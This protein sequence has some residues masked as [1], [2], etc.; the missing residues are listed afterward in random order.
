VINGPLRRNEECDEEDRGD[1]WAERENFGF[2][3]L[4]ESWVLAAKRVGR[5]KE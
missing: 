3:L 5:P 4:V 1:H 2:R